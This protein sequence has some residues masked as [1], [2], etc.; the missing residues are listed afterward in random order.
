MKP[1]EEKSMK[2]YTAVHWLGGEVWRETFEAETDGA[3]L[4]EFE[5]CGPNAYDDRRLLAGDVPL[6]EVRR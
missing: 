5:E 1:K 6:E 2:T 3:A 4:S